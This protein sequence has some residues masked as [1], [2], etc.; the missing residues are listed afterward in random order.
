[1]YDAPERSST[2]LSE[3]FNYKLRKRNTLSGIFFLSLQAMVFYI[4]FPSLND[5]EFGQINQQFNFSPE[6]SY[7]LKST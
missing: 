7:S 3:V 1:M 5:I 6:K 4:F 2:T